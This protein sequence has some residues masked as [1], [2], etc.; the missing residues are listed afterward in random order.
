MKKNGALQILGPL[1]QLLLSTKVSSAPTI[2]HVYVLN[3]LKLQNHNLS[4]SYPKSMRLR[5]Y[6]RSIPFVYTTQLHR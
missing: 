5:N 6:E 4:P 3:I 2:F 1:A